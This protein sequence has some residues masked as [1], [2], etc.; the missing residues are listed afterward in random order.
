M[1]EK[2]EICATNF[3]SSQF[4][5]FSLERLLLYSRVAVYKLAISL[6]EKQAQAPLTLE[7]APQMLH[8]FT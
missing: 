5:I 4:S 8:L 1:D 7:L 2:K 3:S 6:K